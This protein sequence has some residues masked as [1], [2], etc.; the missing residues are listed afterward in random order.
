MKHAAVPRRGTLLRG[1]DRGARGTGGMHG[2]D[3]D[4]PH[5]TARSTD[6][7]TVCIQFMRNCCSRHAEAR[8]R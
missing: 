2:F 8:S 3:E 1:N 5:G 6:R 4:D 7:S